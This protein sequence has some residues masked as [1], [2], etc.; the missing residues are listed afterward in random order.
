M[1]LSPAVLAVVAGLAWSA[2]PT[3]PAHADLAQPPA[4]PSG[5]SWS[6]VPN[7]AGRA[8]TLTWKPSPDDSAGLERVTGYAIERSETPGGPWSVVDSTAHGVTRHDDQTLHRDTDYF[9][10]VAA[11]GPGGRTPA[12]SIT[13]PVRATSQWINQTRWSVLVFMVLFFG[14]VLYYI[15]SA[16]AGRKPF[17]RRIPGID[18]IE[19]AIGRA[20]EM[21]RSVLY[22]PGV[23]DIDD[24]QTVAGLV[25]LESVAKIAARY[26]TPLTVPVAYP[27]PFT[28]A[29]EMVK[30]GYLNSGKPELYDPSSVRFVSPEQFAY[31]AAI[32]GIMLRDKPAAHIF[33]GSFYAESL[34]LAETGFSTG[35]IQVAGTANVHQLPFFVV[36]CDYTL[37]GEELYAAS[38]YL[39]GEPKLI[40]SLKGADLMKLVII[41]GFIL[42]GCTL[43][44]F[45]ITW[46]TQWMITQ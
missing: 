29:E 43:E 14:F 28:I 31:V 18:A 4:P 25:I 20:T 9:Y 21:G 17:V 36:A 12:L 5:L 13:G 30:S 41:L 16:Q 37:I 8:V 27:I 22:V 11:F 3:L 2:V 40:G 42:I 23:Q 38:A 19:E 15:A 10:R 33:M 6:D 26:E 32:T 46:L 39:S 7:D 35:A 1:R 24:I 44:S 34:L 45:H